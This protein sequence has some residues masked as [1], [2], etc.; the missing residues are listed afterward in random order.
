MRV[1]RSLGRAWK[2]G[3]HHLQCH[4]APFQGGTSHGS[5]PVSPEPSQRPLPWSYTGPLGSAYQI[6]IFPG[7]LPVYLKH[8]HLLTPGGRGLEKA[9]RD[10]DTCPLGSCQ[11]P[12]LRVL[13]SGVRGS[14]S[15]CMILWDPWG[16]CLCVCQRYVYLCE[17]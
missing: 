9:P 2:G 5:C 11:Q 4:K 10:G 6:G 1:G 17:C 3:A 8:I 13:D 7:H 16:M 15:D 12:T 14:F